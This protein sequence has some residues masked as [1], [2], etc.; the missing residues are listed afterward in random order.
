MKPLSF[1]LSLPQVKL[2]RSQLAT[3][4][5]YDFRRD[6]ILSPQSLSVYE[7]EVKE[8]HVDYAFHVLL[9]VTRILNTDYPVA[10]VVLI[11]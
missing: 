9:Q 3:E 11:W 7:F 2:P 10:A 1:S 4:P 8:E 6:G 5:E